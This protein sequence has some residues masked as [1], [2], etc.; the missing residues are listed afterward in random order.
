M[1]CPLLNG[2]AIMDCGGLDAAFPSG[3][4]VLR[5]PH[6]AKAV[7]QPPHSKTLRVN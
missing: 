3:G 7:S 2:R 5:T 4:A 1:T 6:K